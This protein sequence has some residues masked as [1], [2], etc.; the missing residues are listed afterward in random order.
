MGDIMQ[1]K[2]ANTGFTVDQLLQG[3]LAKNQFKIDYLPMWKFLD[4]WERKAGG[5]DKVPMK[6]I[7]EGIYEYATVAISL[8][9]SDMQ[10]R[11]DNLNE[12]NL[13]WCTKALDLEKQVELLK[14]KLLEKQTTNES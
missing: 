9:K 8:D 11:I 1:I 13:K 10:T 5:F 3:K 6:D 14:Q 12:Q 2:D 7:F 4:G